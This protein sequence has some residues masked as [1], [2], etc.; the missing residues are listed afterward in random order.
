MT[1][2]TEKTFTIETARGTVTVWYQDHRTAYVRAGLDGEVSTGPLYVGKQALTLRAHFTRNAEGQWTCKQPF[3]S[4]AGEVFGPDP[5]RR[6]TEQVVSAVAVALAEH[7][8][9]SEG[10]AGLDSA[11]WDRRIAEAGE[12]N[13]TAAALREI[14]DKL[15]AD[16]DALR[17]GGNV[18][19][20]E[21]HLTSGF[22]E[23]TRHVRDADGNL[24]AAV[25]ELPTISG[26][27]RYLNPEHMREQRE[28]D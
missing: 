6:M 7:A 22:K 5:T 17:E 9:T 13:A 15:D 1:I 2:A 25:A 3:V 21:T 26:T 11:G 19:Y 4:R 12:R 16:A 24:R 14:A 10:M 20:I 8:E 27:G 23:T 28:I 18:V